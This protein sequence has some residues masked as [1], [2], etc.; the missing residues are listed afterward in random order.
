MSCASARSR[1]VI[2]WARSYCMQESIAQPRSKKGERVKT[3]W[4]DQRLRKL[5]DRY[6]L[7]YWNGQLTSWQIVRAKLKAALGVCYSKHALIEID[8]SSHRNDRHVRATV[9]HEMAHAVARRPGHGLAFFA[10]M[11]MLIRR[12]A[13]V[14]IEHGDSGG[15]HIYGDLVPRRFPL[16]REKMEAMERMRAKQVERYCAKQKL[17]ETQTITANDIIEE[18]GGC[19]LAAYTW[20]VALHA[21]GHEYGLSDDTGRPRNAWSRSIIAKG[22]KRHAATRR[23]HMA[24]LALSR[25]TNVEGSEPVSNNE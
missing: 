9:L 20:K 1:I 14:S 7:L 3:S 22:K 8:I 4:S 25:K 12:G 21:L 6:N 2:P 23:D 24:H 10:Q 11:E 18:F 19:E 15:A 5:F 16:L 13:L 17:T